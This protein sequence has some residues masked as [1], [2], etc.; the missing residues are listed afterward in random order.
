MPRATAAGIGGG[1]A[2]Y[3]GVVTIDSEL[4]S[5]TVTEGHSCTPIGNGFNGWNVTAS[6]DNEPL[7]YWTVSTVKDKYHRD[8]TCWTLTHK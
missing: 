5:I 3:S 6:L 4:T 1:Y 8:V 2:A 7:S